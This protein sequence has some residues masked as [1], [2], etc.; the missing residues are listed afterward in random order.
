MDMFK[1]KYG[2]N[3]GMKGLKRLQEGILECAL[4][5]DLVKKKIIKI[6]GKTNVSK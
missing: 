3:S 6:V 2:R 5:D 1:C 4:Y